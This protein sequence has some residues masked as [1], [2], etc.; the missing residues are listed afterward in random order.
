MTSTTVRSTRAEEIT[1][2]AVASFEQTPSPR[3]R[4][5][6]QAL[7]RHIH[8]FATEVNLTQS[9]WETAIA[10]LTATGDITDEKRSEFILWSDT[11]GLSSLVDA[12]SSNLPAGAME[13]TVLGPFWSANAPIREFGESMIERGEGV[14]AYVH[15]RV[16]SLD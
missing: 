7:V 12:I 2:A 14:P 13:S 3:L 6:V 8:A 10:V 4:E 11:L 9:E 16:T 5:L 15:G 1:R